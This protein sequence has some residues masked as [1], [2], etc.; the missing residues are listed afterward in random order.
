MI[1][2]FA[3]MGAFF[4]ALVLLSWAASCVDRWVFNI[5]LDHWEKEELKDREEEEGEGE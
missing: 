3:V 5:L 1:T 4:F 2:F